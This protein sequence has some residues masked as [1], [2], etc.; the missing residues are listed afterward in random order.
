MAKEFQDNSALD[1]ALIESG[2]KAEHYEITSYGT[3]CTWAE[4]LG[5]TQALELLKQTLSEEKQ[6]DERLTRIAEFSRNRDPMHQDTPHKT[7]V[8]A[9]LTGR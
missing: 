7:G 1:A 6:T 8:W 4:Q 9:K 5:K 3:L 2:Q